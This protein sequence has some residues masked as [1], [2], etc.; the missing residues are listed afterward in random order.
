MGQKHP[1][2]PRQPGRTLLVVAQCGNLPERASR[3]SPSKPQRG[4]R[5]FSLKGKVTAHPR[6]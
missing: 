3:L 1:Q 5:D 4:E 6:Q 2:P